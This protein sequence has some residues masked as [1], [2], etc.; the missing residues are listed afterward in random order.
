MNQRKKCFIKEFTVG[1]HMELKS[2]M[3]EKDI[4]CK[5]TLPENSWKYI[6]TVIAFANGNG[7]QIIFGI[8]DKSWEVTGIPNDVISSWSDLITDAIADTCSPQIVTDINPET[9]DGKTVLVVDVP[10]G[11]QTPY[12]KKSEGK[13]NGTYIRINGESRKAESYMVEQLILEGRNTS[14]DLIPVRGKSLTAYDI[15]KTCSKLTKYAKQ[16]CLDRQSAADLKPLTANQLISFGL[17]TESGKNYIPSNGYCLLEGLPLVGIQNEIQCAVFKGITKTVFI[18]KKTYSG[19][20]Y[21]QIDS[22]YDFVKRNI[23]SSMGISG[24]HSYDIYELPLWAIRELICNAVCHRSLLEPSNIQIS[25]FDD[26]LEIVSPGSIPRGLTISKIRK[27]RSKIRNS[28]IAAVFSYLSLIEKWGTGIPRVIEECVEYGLKEPV[29]EDDGDFKVVIFRGK[30][31]Q[32]NQTNQTNQVNQV[33]QVNQTNQTD[34]ANQVNQT[35]TKLFTGNDFEIGRSKRWFQN[36]SLEEQQVVKTI[37]KEPEITQKKIAL[38]LSWNIN[39]V[40]YFLGKLVKKGIIQR[41]GTSQKGIWK[42]LRQI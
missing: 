36:L 42:L 5:E 1:G 27:G 12:Y 21:E 22:A 11:F 20:L 6:K 23:K 9:I 19:P 26:R 38:T 7:G 3:L 31:N 28:G 15:K 2:L 33:N 24:S 10:R 18:D 41:E 29:F 40:K 16:N 34:Q 13:L 32:T 37:I 8:K 17:L 35:K 39:R 14:F 25:L 4:E 30:V